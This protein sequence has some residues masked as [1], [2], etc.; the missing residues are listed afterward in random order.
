MKK[1]I[2]SFILPIALLCGFLFHKYCGALYFIVPG[3]VFTMLFLNYTAIDVKKMHV[4]GLDGWLLTL[5]MAMSVGFYWLMLKCGLN[6]IMAQGVLIGIL[7]PVAAAVVVISCALGANR[8]TVT[9]YTILDNLAVSIMAPII[10]SFIGQHQD[11]PFL[12]SFWHV[13]WRIAPQIVLPFIV[14]LVLQK[15][16]PKV[17]AFFCKYKGLSLYVWAFT[18]TL[19]LGKTFHDILTNPDTDWGMLAWMCLISAILCAILFGLGKWIGH[20]YGDTVAG[21]QLFGQKNT[22]FGIWMTIEYLNPMAAV[23]PAIYS[24]WQNIFNSYQMFMYDRKHASK[25]D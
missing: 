4:S 21:G 20:H 13:F 19:V 24:V 3:L 12:Q 9:T 23:F 8:E 7:T 2:R 16:A 11:M 17:N 14:A 1:H 6:E 18:L 25:N 10:F 5:Q 15:F 22:S